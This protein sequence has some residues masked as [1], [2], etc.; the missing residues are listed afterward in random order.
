MPRRAPYSKGPLDLSHQRNV[1]FVSPALRRSR[2]KYG[3]RSRV[4]SVGRKL[5]IKRSSR[6]AFF[7]PWW[8]VFGFDRAALYP[9]A[10]RSGSRRL[11]GFLNPNLPEPVEDVI[12]GERVRRDEEKN[13]I[14]AWSLEGTFQQQS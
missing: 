9:P 11:N 2:F 4:T 1:G 12:R 8:V 10:T 14:V 3:A 13:G 5:T 7:L 6:F